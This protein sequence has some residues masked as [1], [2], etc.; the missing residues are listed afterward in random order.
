MIR[1][2]SDKVSM[3]KRKERRNMKKERERKIL[4]TRPVVV[5]ASGSRS[6]FYR[7]ARDGRICVA[8]RPW[9]A[10]AGGDRITWDLDT[11]LQSRRLSKLCSS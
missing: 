4:Y 3:K 7:L 5:R 10:V 2:V 11:F 8:G 1:P 6:I 9:L